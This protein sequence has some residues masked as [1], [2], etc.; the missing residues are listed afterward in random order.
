[1]RDENRTGV[2]RLAFL[3]FLVSG[4]DEEASRSNILRI[5]DLKS[6][7]GSILSRGDSRSTES[8][9][10]SS[11]SSASAIL[12]YFWDCFSLDKVG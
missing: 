7:Y 10:S 3:E 4:A 6:W 8:S 5:V 1:M 9:P 2:V 11:S 12:P